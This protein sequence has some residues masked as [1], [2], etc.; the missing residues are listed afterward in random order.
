MV[1]TRICGTGCSTLKTHTLWVS[2]CIV[3]PFDLLKVKDQRARLGFA[4]LL[5]FEAFA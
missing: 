4:L 2:L 3:Y 5:I 1:E